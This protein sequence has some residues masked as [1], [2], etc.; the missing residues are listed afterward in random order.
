MLAR[1]KR[2]CSQGIFFFTTVSRQ[3]LGPTEPPIQWVP[4]P[5]FLGV[6]G[7]EHEADHSLPCRADVK[8]A[9]NYT[10]ILPL[11]IHRAMLNLAMNAS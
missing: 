1:V 11:C 7:L 3:N 5:L 6:K 9:W 2:I 8:N 4:G 10:T